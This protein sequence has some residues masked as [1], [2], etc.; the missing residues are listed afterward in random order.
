MIIE[1]DVM[2]PT[3]NV[4]RT[5]IPGRLASGACGRGKIRICVGV[6]APIPWTIPTTNAVPSRIP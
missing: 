3:R 5:A 6:S 2:S 4:I 1:F